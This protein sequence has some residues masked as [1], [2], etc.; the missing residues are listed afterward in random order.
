M[1][2]ENP[3]AATGLD[4]REYFIDARDIQSDD[5]PA[6]QLET[7]MRARAREKLD[8]VAPIQTFESGVIAGN[9]GAFR[10]LTDYDLGDFVTTAN[11]KAG[12]TADA[13]INV[14]VESYTNEGFKIDVEIGEPIRGVERIID[15]RTSRLNGELFR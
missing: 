9:F 2:E 3:T 12:L 15:I 7:I 13:Q 5:V 8:E 14:I 11:L 6:G 10:Y 1:F 4:R